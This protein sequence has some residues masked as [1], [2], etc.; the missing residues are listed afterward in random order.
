MHAGALHAADVTDR[1]N[2]LTLERALFG[3]EYL[4]AGGAE[5]LLIPD[6]VAHYVG[7]RETGRR[8]LAGG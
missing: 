4:F 5:A 7:L 2:E 3:G 1:A 8:E 6:L